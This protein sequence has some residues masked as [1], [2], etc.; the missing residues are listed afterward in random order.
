MKTLPTLL[1]G[2]I[3]CFS[4]T[5]CERLFNKAPRVQDQTFSIDEN[6]PNG[7]VV[8]E[9][10]AKD[11]SGQKLEFTISSGNENEAFALD[12]KTGILTVKNYTLLNYET[13]SSFLLYVEVEDEFGKSSEAEITISLVNLPEI[14]DATLSVP[15]NSL[16]GVTVGTLSTPDQNL[17]FAITEGNTNNAFA[18][19]ST[20]VITVNNESMFDFETTPSF[21]LTVTATNAQSRVGTAH[22]TVNLQNVTPPTSNLV[23]YMPFDGNVNDLSSS[24]NNG[25]DYTTSPYVEGKWGQAKEFNGSSDY[26]KLT[27]T[28]DNATGVSVSFWVKTYGAL[29]TEN[30]AVIISKYS[31]SGDLQSFIINSCGVT[32]NRGI[33]RIY[34]KYG[35]EPQVFD[36]SKS[37]LD[38]S[39]LPV[40]TSLWTIGT[41]K[42][43]T[44]NAWS[45]CIVNV[46]STDVETWIDGVLCAKRARAYTSYLNSSSIETL[47][48]NC[49]WCGQGS[50]NHFHG[51][52]DEL[53]VYNRSLTE[54]EIQLLFKEI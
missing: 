48:G 46:T 32:T 20:G 1:I 53:R 14:T 22:I 49:A 34:A 31:M 36:F 51:A 15:E 50:N 23:L 8:G 41:Q 43:L 25:I 29:E 24:G 4:I 42:V 54:A 27:N 13:T 40:N 12:K 7:T 47:I 52:L 18:I 6:S 35:G 33:N 37:Q 39:D 21:N 16:A 30:N 17:T 26:I 38:D 28:I 3:L 45:H 2:L 44:L 9:I 19:S 5:S 10:I 11:K